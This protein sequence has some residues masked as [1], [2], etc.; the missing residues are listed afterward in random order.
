MHTFLEEAED[1]LTAGA[2]VPSALDM[3]TNILIATLI[4]FII[5][6][7]ALCFIVIK[8]KALSYN[9]VKHKYEKSLSNVLYISNGNHV[10]LTDDDLTMIRREIDPSRIK[11][12]EDNT[13]END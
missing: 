1:F 5:F 13:N 7:I 9:M 11:I 6:R 8:F 3:A 2:N 10:I 12:I 4:T